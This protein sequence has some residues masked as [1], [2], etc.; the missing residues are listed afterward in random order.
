MILIL[1]CRYLNQ[2][3]HI[4][5]YRIIDL[6]LGCR[7]SIYRDDAAIHLV[8]I[9]HTVHA[10]RHRFES[11]I[12]GLRSQIGI[13]YTAGRECAIAYKGIRSGVMGDTCLREGLR[14]RRF[15]C[16]D[17]IV[18]GGEY[19]IHTFRC[20]NAGRGDNLIVRVRSCLYIFNILCIQISLGFRDR[21]CGVRL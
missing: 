6:K 4:C 7:L 10:L 14:D 8:E 20:Q 12:R 1:R 3:S 21:G 9:F 5:K 19:R 18:G 16:H 13:V 11:K 17:D 2:F 15:S